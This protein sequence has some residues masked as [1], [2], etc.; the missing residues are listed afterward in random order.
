MP[1]VF[2]REVVDEVLAC[3]DDDAIATAHKLSGESGILAGMSCGAAVWAAAEVGSRPENKGKKIV[4]VLP[5]SGE[6]YISAP[7]FAP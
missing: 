1:E 5:D 4:T 6:R 2:N 3:S 7:F